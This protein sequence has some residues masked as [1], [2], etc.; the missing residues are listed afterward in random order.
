MRL[1]PSPA[2]VALRLLPTSTWRA[3]PALATPTA[4]QRGQQTAATPPS[5][6]AKPA[7][8]RG[9]LDNAAEFV[10]TKLDDLINWARKVRGHVRVTSVQLLGSRVLSS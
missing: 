1:P 4:H 3:L 8:A 7:G 6:A 10:V 2:S 9:K 5:T